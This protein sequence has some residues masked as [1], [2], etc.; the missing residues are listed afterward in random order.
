MEKEMLISAANDSQAHLPTIFIN[1][2]KN[3]E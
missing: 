3:Q 2:I 1:K